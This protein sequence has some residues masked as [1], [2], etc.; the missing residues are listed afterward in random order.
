MDR[1]SIV[2][3]NE[4]KKEIMGLHRI[5]KKLLRE[6]CN[7]HKLY[8][9]PAL[10]D[11]LYLHFQG[12]QY[13]EELEEYTELKCLWLESNA[14]CKI[15]GLQNQTKLKCLF[16]HSNLITRI[17]NLDS[18]KLL[19]NLNLSSNHI[20]KIENIGSEILPMLNSLNLSS[21]YLKD[22]ESLQELENCS[23]LSVLDLSNNR[24]D[25]LLVVKI[26][27]KMSRLR[28]LILQGNPI[29]SM[30]PQY[31]KTLILECKELTYLDSRPVFPKDRACAEA[32]RVGGY[33]AENAEH[34]KWARKERK[35]MTDSINA[36]IRLRNKYKP[37]EDQTSLIG[38][39]SEDDEGKDANDLWKEVEDD[40]DT[41]IQPEYTFN[42][43]KRRRKQK[44][45]TVDL[46]EFSVV[47]DSDEDSS[48]ELE[49]DSPE[50]ENSSGET[51]SYEFEQENKEMVTSN[52]NKDK[53]NYFDSTETTEETFPI[54]SIDISQLGSEKV[55]VETDKEIS[56]NAKKMSEIV[57]NMDEDGVQ[58][59]Y[60]KTVNAIFKVVNNETDN[61]NN[62]PFT[63]SAHETFINE[64]ETYDSNEIKLESKQTDKMDNLRVSTKNENRDDKCTAKSLL[65]DYLNKADSEESNA[66]VTKDFEELSSN[67]DAFIEEFQE[68]NIKRDKFLANSNE[69]VEKD[70]SLGIE[71]ESETEFD[72][73]NN[74]LQIE[75]THLNIKDITELNNN[76]DIN[77]TVVVK[78]IGNSDQKYN[79]SMS[80]SKE[81]ENNQYNCTYDGNDANAANKISSNISKIS[82]EAMNEETKAFDKYL[83]EFYNK[84]RSN[85]GLMRYEREERELFEK[86]RKFEQENGYDDLIAEKTDKEKLIDNNTVSC[87]KETVNKVELNTSFKETVS[88][89]KN[90]N[91]NV[92]FLDCCDSNKVTNRST[93][94]ELIAEN[95]KMATEVCDK[96]NPFIIQSESLVQTGDIDGSRENDV[97]EEDNVSKQN[98]T[99]PTKTIYSV[100]NSFNEFVNQL[101]I[102]QRNRVV[103]K[104][105]TISLI[106]K[107][108]PLLG[109]YKTHYMRNLI[110]SPFFKRFDHNI[111][112]PFNEEILE[113]MVK[114][115]KE[116][117]VYNEKDRYTDKKLVDNKTISIWNDDIEN[118][119]DF[120]GL[121]GY[122][123]EDDVQF[124]VQ[125]DSEKDLENDSESENIFNI[126]K[127]KKELSGKAKDEAKES[128]QLVLD[129]NGGNDTSSDTERLT[130][131][132]Q[133]K[134]IKT[135]FTFNNSNEFIESPNLLLQKEKEE[136]IKNDVVVDITNEA[137]PCKSI[138]EITD[139]N[140]KNVSLDDLLQELENDVVLLKNL[141]ILSSPNCFDLNSNKNL[142]EEE[143]ITRIEKD[144]LILEVLDDKK[145]YSTEKINNIIH[146]DS[147]KRCILSCDNA[148]V[149]DNLL[150]KDVSILSEYDE[151]TP[152]LIKT[153]KVFDDKYKLPK[154]IPHKDESTSNENDLSVK[155]NNRDSTAV[156]SHMQLACDDLIQGEESIPTEDDINNLILVNNINKSRSLENIHKIH[157]TNYKNKSLNDLLQEVENDVVLL[158]NLR[159]LCGTSCNKELVEEAKITSMK[160]NE[161]ILDALDD[162][163]N[164]CTENV[165][166]V[167]TSYDNAEVIDYTLQEKLSFLNEYDGLTTEFIKCNNIV[168]ENKS[169][170]A[171]SYEDIS[172]LHE[173]N[174]SILTTNKKQVS[175]D[176]SLEGSN[177][178][179]N[180]N[181]IFSK[182]E[183]LKF[184]TATSKVVKSYKGLVFIDG[185]VVSNLSS[186]EEPML[187]KSIEPISEVLVDFDNCGL[188]KVENAETEEI[189]NK[190]H[191]IISD[192][193]NK[194]KMSVLVENYENTNA[195][196]ISDVS[197]EE[198]DG[199]LKKVLLFNKVSS[200]EPQNNAALSDHESV[201]ELHKEELLYNNVIGSEPQN[202]AAL[203]D[204]E[205][206]SDLHKEE[207]L[208][209]NVIGSEP[210]NIA[211]L[212]DHESVSDLH[213]EE[214]LY[215]N[216]IGSE[217][218]NNTVLSDD[219]SVSDL[220][221]EELLFNNVI[222]S[223]LQNNTAL[224]DHESVSDLHKEE[225]LYNN[226]IGSEPRNI[227]AL[228][229]HESVS[230]LHKEEL[231]YNNVIGSEP[232]NNTVLSDDKS[233]SDLHKEELLFNNVI[234]SELQNNTALFDHESVSDL[235]K[236][237]VLYN[238]VIGS[239][240]QNNT[241]LS[242]QEAVSDLHKEELLHN[243]II[244]SEQQNN[245]AL[246]DQEAVS[247]LHKEEVL[248]N[249]VIGSEP[250]NNTVLS[251]DKSVSDLHKE[252]LLFN[253]VIGS[254]LQNNTALSDHESVSDLHKE[255]LLYNNVIGSEPQNNADLSDHEAVSDLHKEELLHNK[256]IGSEQQNNA[257]L[258]D[259]EAVSDLHKEEVL[260]NNVIGSEPQNN[261]VLSD[262]KSVSDLHKEELLY[263][264]V[265]GSEP[266][267]I[268]ALSDHESVSD[269][270]KE[271]LLYNNVIGSEPQNIG[272]L[273]DHESVSDLHKEELLYTKVIG[274]EPQNNA[275]L[276]D[277][278]AVSDLHKEEVLYNNVI[279]SEPQ[280]NT[281]ISDQEAVSDLHKEEVLFNN[282]IGSEPQNNTAISDYESVTELAKE[283]ILFNNVI[284]SE[285]QNNA[286]LSVD[287]SVSD[288]HKEGVLFNNVIASEPQ[289]IDTLSDD[290]AVSLDD[291]IHLEVITP[292]ENNIEVIDFSSN[293]SNCVAKFENL[294]D[295]KT[296]TYESDESCIDFNACHLETKLEN[297]IKQIPR[298]E[299][300]QYIKKRKGKSRY[301]AKYTMHVKKVS[302]KYNNLY[303]FLGHKFKR[304]CKH[305]KLEY[306][307]LN[308]SSDLSLSENEETEDENSDVNTDIQWDQ[309]DKFDD[310][311]CMKLLEQNEF[312][313]ICSLSD[314][315]S[316][317]ILPTDDDSS[318]Q[319]VEEF[320]TN[321]KEQKMLPLNQGL[322][323]ETVQRCADVF[324]NGTNLLYPSWSDKS[325]MTKDTSV[326]ENNDNLEHEKS[327][328][329]YDRTFVNDAPND[330]VEPFENNSQLNESEG[331]FENV[332]TQA[333]FSDDADELQLE[334]NFNERIVSVP[335]DV[336][337][338]EVFNINTEGGTGNISNELISEGLCNADVGEQQTVNYY[339][340]HTEDVCNNMRVHGTYI[341][342]SG[343]K[344]SIQTIQKNSSTSADEFSFDGN[345]GDVSKDIND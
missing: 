169:L 239:E 35:K 36:T 240:P 97:L 200:S 40:E 69:N 133:S 277:Q 63:T 322:Q 276:S 207:L 181:L 110:N 38:T 244:G 283:E 6:L 328:G 120:L 255:E 269:L 227:A 145:N 53:E 190:K 325:E 217:P 286:A 46:D 246:S 168:S 211:A 119:K 323:Y 337:A 327:N 278:E 230:D 333:I 302:V 115:I 188:E 303:K 59:E 112:Y 43:S 237:E 208:Y 234:D 223:E 260:F 187:H 146:L 62:V 254:E 81:N 134:D 8:Q 121:K 316:N 189:K 15:E 95:T 113:M 88:R 341:D 9:T 91:K 249:N 248:F 139:N 164:H 270:H 293:V 213:K 109:P 20:R 128:K 96:I 29:V 100:L 104:E 57:N 262:D 23:H 298:L 264:N 294:K 209:N 79:L 48:S 28:V 257:A 272:A 241:D 216:V 291:L 229:D 287:K 172:T 66:Q 343:S 284:D 250:Q 3:Q 14:I 292:D 138:E 243:K 39:S 68:H 64:L 117:R 26:F 101:S 75:D 297:D 281:A 177:Y 50:T 116:R 12:I 224:F 27:A 289:N 1:S 33:E 307:K 86:L 315:F 336:N 107:Y 55:V 310:I 263:N 125:Y 193:E 183:L 108:A 180:K 42:K 215:N 242:D 111:R 319:M 220:H 10:N 174:L 203:S 147:E 197:T 300:L 129:Y 2:V 61:K 159:N 31:R 326:S 280:N 143:N 304:K 313:S 99:N 123:S 186:W 226:V 279:G 210:R 334:F 132:V 339:T 202:I 149:K 324:E 247:D 157:V 299:A 87:F 235:H 311:S 221:K 320:L 258:S 70:F 268:A 219:K 160:N 52:N 253:N 19:D 179:C 309:Y 60:V 290:E 144:E 127:F 83:N 175:I 170:N 106:S 32:W 140:K 312:D 152:E 251:D 22:A 194:E 317:N 51:N 185:N 93:Y 155:E 5:T 182:D 135:N 41:C 82:Y 98:I 192:C 342:E 191:Y 47:P 236:E 167:S 198:C 72:F 102:Q 329:E 114:N 80:F 105:T 232:Q 206:V 76:N 282:V 103:Q 338:E 161:L 74:V 245:A 37:P 296:I 25:D 295:L 331:I 67:M 13:I 259:Q 154:A 318:T 77:E 90:Q 65:L 84:T 21:N 54:N 148:L 131:M 16:L 204:H 162:K 92:S 195:Q 24:I 94:K 332:H 238:N 85:T 34:K 231:L 308:N 275:A 314:K 173:N 288:L 71:S 222:D 45:K 137:H 218:Q 305:S 153:N 321:F 163:S 18:C 344:T 184:E 171:S 233:V 274:S 265:I 17:E 122:Y 56:I 256:I 165:Q 205:S 11:V 150:Q 252:E 141:K 49:F 126:C 58:S 166:K 340:E 176:D 142:V 214:L 73:G 225:V 4:Q 306:S 212:S 335:Y 118:I 228:S 136:L 261:T 285:P 266:Q 345:C 30:L 271:E 7:K 273:S 130:N 267:N 330:T 89:S 178:N 301:V 156:I 196:V 78:S 158:K 199:L 44:S 124:E 151:L 201:S